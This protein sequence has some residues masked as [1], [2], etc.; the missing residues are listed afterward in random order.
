MK[1]PPKFKL[2]VLERDWIVGVSGSN[3]FRRVQACISRIEATDDSVT[4]QSVLIAE[5]DPVEFA[6]AFFAGVYTGV[7]IILANPKWQQSEWEQLRGLVNPAIAFGE[8]G[9]FETEG[10][11]EVDHPKRGTI[12]IPTGG[13]SGKLKLAVHTWETLLASCQG[14]HSFIGVGPIHSCC[15]LQLYHVSGL[16][17]LMRSFVSGGQIVF[18]DY[19]ALEVGQLPEIAAERLC[20]SLVP[21]QLQRMLEQQATTNWLRGLRAIFLGGAPMSLGLRARAQEYRLPVVPTY[22][23]TET[24]AMATALPAS[25]FL[26][27]NSSVGYSLNH[28]TVQVVRENGSCCLPEETGRIHIQARSLCL[29]YH[30]LASEIS[31]E[32]YLSMDEGYLDHEGCLH[33]VGRSDRIIISGGENIDPLEVEAAFLKSGM[34]EQALVIGW[35]DPEWGERLVAFYVAVDESGNCKALQQHLQSNL[36]NYKIPRQIIQVEQLPLSAQS[37]PDRALIKK[38]LEKTE[39]AERN[40]L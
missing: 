17:Q 20:L 14:F 11:S 29:G 27:G 35:P 23:M 31:Q 10:V 32:G 13:S 28:A 2:D 8:S 21:T 19:K 6:A 9:I 18:T 39:G 15:V 16:M 37:K 26:A 5:A 25:A 34:V 33:I 1:T 36:V 38:L 40:L 24:A 4:E 30:G 7:S 22:G 12:L 3:F